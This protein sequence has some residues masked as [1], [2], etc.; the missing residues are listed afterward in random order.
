M[1]PAVPDGIVLPKAEGA[2][3]LKAL[4]SWLPE[5]MLI[6]PIATE[7]PAAIFSAGTYGGIT[8]RLAGLTWGAEDLPAAIGAVTAREA[9]GRY[10]APYELARALTLFG[11]HRAEEHTSELQS[12][13]STS[14]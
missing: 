7:T 9:D 14:Y 8:D 6:L 10:T 12:L 5:N 13:K 1:L 3:S 11:A 4:D 2:S